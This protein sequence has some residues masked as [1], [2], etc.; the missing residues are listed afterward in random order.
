MSSGRGMCYTTL[1]KSGKKTGRQDTRFSVEKVLADFQE[2]EKS[3]QRKG[4]FKIE[5]PFEKALDTILKVPHPPKSKPARK[6]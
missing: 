1:M 2:A 3:S 6:K 5:A 4:T